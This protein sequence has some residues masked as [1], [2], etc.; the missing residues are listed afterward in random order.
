MTMAMLREEAAQGVGQVVATPHFYAH[1]NRIGQFLEKADTASPTEGSTSGKAE[2]VPESPKGHNDNKVTTK[3]EKD[4]VTVTKITGKNTKAG[5]AVK[6][7]TQADSTGKKR[8]VT[9]IAKNTFNSKAGQNV[10]KVILAVQTKT[11]MS[12]NASALNKSKVSK[13]I[14][15]LSKKNAKIKIRKNAFKGTKTKSPT[16]KI[17]AK[18]ASQI[19]VAKGAFKGLNKNAKIKVSGLSDKEFKKL[20]KALVK[21]GFKGKITKSKK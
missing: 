11:T 17:T 2:V 15:D 1:R 14:I 7:S 20:K 16:I 12:V 10:K 21:A 6:I 13:L 3:F 18:K 19:S 9:A 5:R 4:S 8:A